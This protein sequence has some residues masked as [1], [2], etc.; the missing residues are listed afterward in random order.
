MNKAVSCWT[1]ANFVEYPHFNRCV[2]LNWIYFS[3]MKCSGLWVRHRTAWNI[4]GWSSHNHVRR[5][6][7]V[8]LWSIFSASTRVLNFRELIGCAASIYVGIVTDQK[9]TLLQLFRRSDSV[10]LISL[11]TWT[12]LL[13]TFI[14][15][16]LF[17]LH[18]LVGITVDQF[19]R[20]LCESIGIVF[21]HQ[22]LPGIYKRS[23]WIRVR[24]SMVETRHDSATD[25]S[26][27]S[28]VDRF[29]WF[30][31]FT[32]GDWINVFITVLKGITTVYDFVVF[33]PWYLWENPAER[34]NKSNRLKVS[35]VLRH[36]LVGRKFKTSFVWCDSHEKR[37]RLIVLVQSPLLLKLVV[38]ILWSLRHVMS[39]AVL[40]ICKTNGLKFNN[41][42]TQIVWA[43]S[44]RA[45]DCTKNYSN[46]C[47]RYFAPHEP[48]FAMAWS[49]ILAVRRNTQQCDVSAMTSWIDKFDWVY[50]NTWWIIQT[51]HVFGH[52]CFDGQVWTSPH[53][54]PTLG[55]F[56][57][58][59]HFSELEQTRV[60]VSLTQSV[61]F[62]LILVL[63]C[64]PSR[65][66]TSP[67][68]RTGLWTTQSWQPRCSQN[69]QHL[70]ISSTGTAVLSGLSA[71]SPVQGQLVCDV[72]NDHP[73][74]EIHSFVIF[75]RSCRSMTDK[76][77]TLFLRAVRLYGP[78]D[79][80]GTREQLSEED[81]LQP[82]GKVFKKVG[83][84]HF[85]TFQLAKKN[86]SH[87]HTVDVKFQGIS[88]YFTRNL[89]RSVDSDWFWVSEETPP[90][91]PFCLIWESR[92]KNEEPDSTQRRTFVLGPQGFDPCARHAQH[93]RYW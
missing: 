11:W 23:A 84:R 5:E 13:D 75:N 71:V 50:P 69:A 81:E 73:R 9:D 55:A 51:T 46:M 80:L 15:T 39:S 70:M 21:I 34:L 78:L 40:F 64:R 66:R 43:L 26:S 62:L 89:L 2:Q 60:F 19:P 58:Y 22:S 8:N 33:I 76:H 35:I 88:A 67:V 29:C 7:Y 42:V 4:V 56:I 82:N 44:R 74:Y 48:F 28:I 85:W 16:V 24:C 32:M 47:Q 3:M 6:C 10:H 54:C 92:Q 27:S 36:P 1:T 14:W 25:F 65:S 87:S 93:L 59:F 17:L 77:W 31:A 61:I 91:L 79:C 45:E 72:Q 57:C 63:S 68:A 12:T 53:A 86:N 83:F 30:Q 90:P 52:T 37:A 49:R 38:I 20:T 41:R 18:C